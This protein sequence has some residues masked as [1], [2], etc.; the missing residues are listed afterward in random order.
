MTVWLDRVRAPIALLA[1]LTTRHRAC[2]L[3]GDAKY[4]IFCAHDIIAGPIEANH[5]D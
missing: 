5:D 3:V 1:A 2:L 4:V